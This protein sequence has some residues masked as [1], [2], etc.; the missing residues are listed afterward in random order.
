MESVRLGS[1]TANGTADIGKE[2]TDIDLSSLDDAFRLG[3]TCLVRP[4]S[5]YA[6]SFC[7]D[8]LILG[9][10][11]FSTA[12]GVEAQKESAVDH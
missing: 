7:I 10:K 2:S 12:V 6:R 4:F 3:K 9:S 5:L 8:D 11:D 1:S